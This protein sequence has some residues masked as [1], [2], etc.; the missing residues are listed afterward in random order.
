MSEEQVAALQE[1]L[2]NM[3]P[4]ELKEFQQQQCIFCHIVS[5]KVQSKKIY[6]DDKVIGILDINPSNPGHILLIPKD[7]YQIMPLVPEEDIAHTFIAAKHLSQA[8]LKAIKC[9][10]TTIFVANGAVAGQRAQHFMVHIIPRMEDDDIQQLNIKE[11]KITKKDQD[12]LLKKLK[13][14]VN[15]IFGK[16]PDIEQAPDEEELE[17]APKEKKEPVAK[18]PAPRR[19]VV[20]ADFKEEKP[21]KTKKKTKKKGEGADLDSIADLLGGQ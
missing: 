8:C 20:E 15:Q 7:H 18:K 12:A 3:S 16:E 4:E 13:T 11:K 2:K 1:K 19:R 21:K 10:G 14:R 17:E 6:E 5:G 9:Q